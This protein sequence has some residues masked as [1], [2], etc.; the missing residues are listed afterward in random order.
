MRENHARH[1]Q[2]ERDSAYRRVDFRDVYRK[3]KDAG[4]SWSEPDG[5]MSKKKKRAERDVADASGAD[6]SGLLWCIWFGAEKSKNIWLKTKQWKTVGPFLL[7]VLFILTCLVRGSRASTRGARSG[8]AVAPVS[9]PSDCDDE[10]VDAL[11]CDGEGDEQEQESE[12]SH[13]P[14]HVAAD[15]PFFAVET[16]MLPPRLRGNW[17]DVSDGKGDSQQ[18]DANTS[19]L[20]PCRNNCT[21]PKQLHHWTASSSLFLISSFPICR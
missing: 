14:A 11:G 2:G 12:A 8:I 4:V 7:R 16:I 21:V 17:P 5:A 3:F 15:A 13:D 1:E 9:C 18:R 6:S 10:E 19:A 20:G